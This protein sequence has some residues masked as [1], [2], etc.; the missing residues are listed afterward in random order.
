MAMV[1]NGHMLLGDP[2]FSKTVALVSAVCIV[3]YFLLPW[4]WHRTGNMVLCSIV[5]Q[6]IYFIHTN[7]QI[8]SDTQYLWRQEIFLIGPP[9]LALLLVGPRAAW[10]ATLLVSVNLVGIALVVESLPIGAAAVVAVV[11]F[12]LMVG[13]SLFHSEIVRKE[14]R[15]TELRD[16][17]ERADREKS[18]FLAKMSHEIRTPLNGLSGILQLLDESD[19]TEDQKDL[20]HTG[21]MSGRNLMRLINDVLDYSKIAAHGVTVENIPFASSDLL[22]TVASAQGVAAKAKGLTLVTEV[23]PDVPEWVVSDPTRLNQVVTNLVGN[24]IKFSDSGNI[25]LKLERSED[26]LLVTV[27]DEGI[28]LTQ[29]AQARVFNKFEQASSTTN[30]RFGGTGLGLAISKE[31]VEL[32]GGEI[33]VSSSPLRGSTFW[34]TIP[35]V[36]T[37]APAD[38]TETTGPQTPTSFEGR[39]V[40]VVEDNKTNQMIARRF[41]ESMGVIVDMVDDGRPALQKCATQTFDLI[42]MDIQLPDMDGVTATEILRDNV[43][44][45]QNTPIVALSAN[46]LPEQTNSY[47]KAG[48]N[49]CLGKPFRKDELATIMGGLIK[50]DATRQ[51][52]A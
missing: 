24:A 2:Q 4:L 27:E 30:R 36:E 32:M 47:L 48:M 12:T 6:I 3:G 25:T 35:C 1:H 33:G 11:A 18:E 49:A 5:I 42:L 31:L 16:E 29:E 28:G 21:R 23:A 13:L 37:I 45:N 10:I 51:P 14:A 17:A 43:G 26:N 20:V 38:P 41:L 52:A 22:S 15:L 44:P 9:V 8:T 46:I 19:L 34:F 40:L 7:V 50:C 39:K